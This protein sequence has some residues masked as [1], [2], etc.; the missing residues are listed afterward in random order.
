MLKKSTLCAPEIEYLGFILIQGC[1]IPQ[2]SK[3]QAIFAIQL[4]KGVKQLSHFMA[5]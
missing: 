2:S 4:P 1:I 3:V 5:W